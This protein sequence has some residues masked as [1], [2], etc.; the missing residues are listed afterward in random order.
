MILGEPADHKNGNGLNNR[1]K[2]LRPANK[3]Q[4]AQNKGIC[5][6]KKS[7]GCK[8]V[9]IVKDRNGVPAYWIARITVMGKR[10]YLGVFKNHVAASR[11]YIKA[12]KELHGEYARWK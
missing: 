9:S 3:Y 5:A 8:G 2:N 12:A 4:Q 10:K 1:R 11:A 7:K 6:H